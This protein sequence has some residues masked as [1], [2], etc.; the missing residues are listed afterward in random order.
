MVFPS[1]HLFSSWGPSEMK[2]CVGKENNCPSS[3]PPPKA[4][5]IITPMIASY[6][7]YQNK[8]KHKEDSHTLGTVKTAMYLKL[9]T[10]DSELVLQVKALADKPD[11]LNLIPKTNIVEEK[12]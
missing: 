6:A 5:W 11:A 7:K 3:E 12:N 4:S 8:L 2:L 10:W 9:F 1:E